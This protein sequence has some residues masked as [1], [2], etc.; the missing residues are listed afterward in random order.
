MDLLGR[1]YLI[2]TPQ[3]MS[4]ARGQNRTGE[5]ASRLWSGLEQRSLP[6]KRLFFSCL[7]VTVVMRLRQLKKDK[8]MDQLE[9]WN[10]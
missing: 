6:Q 3:D 9:L 5:P 1:G 7:G 8:A 10:K 2:H 4:C